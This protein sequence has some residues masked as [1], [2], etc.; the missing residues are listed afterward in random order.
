MRRDCGPKRSAVPDYPCAGVPL[1]GTFGPN[2]ATC[3][4]WERSKAG[5]CQIRL[6]V[7][8]GLR[9]APLLFGLGLLW[10]FLPACRPSS[11][12]EPEP[13]TTRRPY[14]PSRPL[15]GWTLLCNDPTA[16]TPALVWNGLLGVRIGRDGLGAGPWD[17]PGGFLSAHHYEATDQE[18]ILPLPNPFRAVVRLDGRAIQPQMGQGYSQRLDMRTAVLQT[19]Y[20]IPSPSGTPTEVVTEAIA[21]PS[22]GT[23]GH[24]VIV[25]PDGPCEVAISVPD[26]LQLGPESKGLGV[27]EFPLTHEAGGEAVLVRARLRAFGTHRGVWRS[28]ESETTWT[29]SVG[30][31]G[32]LVFE[33]VVR[34]PGAPPLT[35][36]AIAQAA[37]NAWRRRWRTDI[38]ITGP[39]EDQLAV[40]SFLFYLR[41]AM[42]PTAPVAISPFATSDPAY[43]GHVFWDADVWVFPA[44]ALLDP[45]AARSIPTYRLA[46]AQ[47]AQEN[48]R[49]GLSGAQRL[50]ASPRAIQYPWE[51]SVSGLETGR[52]PTRLEH[53]VTGSVLWGL[54]LASILGLA[55]PEPVDRIGRMCAEFWMH[56]AKPSAERPREFEVRGVVSPDE[57]K[58]GDNDLYTNLLAQWTVRTFKDPRIAFKLPRDSS[59]YLTYDGDRLRSYKQHAALLALYPLQWPQAEAE[60]GQMLRRYLGKTA[61][62]GPAMSLSLEALLL[63]RHG[64]VEG[65][66]ETWKESWSLYADH[67]LLLFSEYRNRSL[68]YFTTGPAMCLQ[69]LLFGFLGFRVDNKASS[70]GNWSHPLLRGY[71]L[72]ARPRLP[73]LWKAVRIKNLRVLNQSFDVTCTH[74]DFRITEGGN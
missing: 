72:T 55:P 24:R 9:V 12:P 74:G 49:R 56:R 68:T 13:E 71:V 18:R 2:R 70:T 57:Y 47:A 37:K 61:E 64:D 59:T 40:R 26:R 21:H 30:A 7:R 1:I 53:H 31:G 27:Q 41:S 50:E 22:L 66:Y 38:E 35:F 51:S 32:K 52:A 45:E 44:L 36:D 58:F 73:K 69:S 67:P 63:A 60:A 3:G 33:R 25:R 19:Q 6:Q 42:H 29:G 39:L 15:D 28:A 23:I 43:G 62:N 65:A 17:R 48:L 54:W 8:N 5:L 11:V 20:R 10:T 4:L 16:E 14:V 46:R 34:L